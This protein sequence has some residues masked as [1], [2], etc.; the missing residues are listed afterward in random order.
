MS[1]V[2]TAVV[3]RLGGQ[4]LGAVG[5]AN[6]IFF[7]CSVLGTG[8][9]M[10]LDPLVSQALGRRDPQGA[11]RLLWQGV[12][13]AFFV[14]LV[15]TVPI[16]LGPTFLRAVGI[17]TTVVDFVGRYL[18]IRMLALI[19]LLLFVGLRAYLQAHAITRPMV[20]STIVANVFNL[21]A[22]IV[23]V[24]GGASLPL[25]GSLG[26]L[27]GPLDTIPALG[28][29]GAAIATLLCTLLQFGIVAMAVRRLK[30]S[31][32]E[33]ANR[34]FASGEAKRAFLVGLPVGLQ[35]GAEVGIFALVGLLAGRLGS[36]HLAAHQISLTLVSFSFCVA[37]GIG[38]A[39]SVRVGRAVGA[40]DRHGVRTSGLVA[41][42]GG[43]LFMVSS[44]VVYLLVPRQLA[45]LLTNDAAAIEAAMP[46]IRVAAFFQLSDG[47]QGVGAGVLRGAGDT[48]YPFLANLVGHYVIGLPVALGLT[49]WL[50]LGVSG[51][52]WGLCVGLT[53][54]GVALLRRFLHLSARPIQ[55]IA[56]GAAAVAP[57]PG[58]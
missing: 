25:P 11:R 43:S 16:A 36:T 21:A 3:G 31:G 24:F 18:G 48:R 39:G 17:E 12:W 54:V 7:V 37:V 19:P 27:R 57:A 38:A 34:G 2:D 15:L 44:A 14:G 41:F 26:W 30:V 45:G 58:G 9:M 6:A 42:A 28:V 23:L 1:I 53:V 56:A 32:F 52:W 29:Q 33:Q 46:L 40:G 20:I 55:P 47:I 51:L 22:D 50:D 10:G 35:M 5:L 4:E 13:L 8:T 49:W